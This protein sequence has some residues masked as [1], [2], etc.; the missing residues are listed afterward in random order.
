MKITIIEKPDI[1]SLTTHNQLNTLCEACRGYE[2][3][4]DTEGDDSFVHV[5]ALDEHG[6]LVGFLG[7][8]ILDNVVEITALV[9]PSFRKQGIFKAMLNKIKETYKAKKFIGTI[10][11]EF[12]QAIKDSSIKPEYVHSELLMKLDNNCILTDNISDSYECM[13]SDDYENFLMYSEDE[14]EPVAVCN[15]DFAGSFTNISGVF[16]DEDMR[17]QGIGTIFM[18]ELINAY[19]EEFEVPVILHVN[20]NNIAAIKLYEKCGFKTAECVDYYRF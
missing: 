6:N 16:V 10:P 1:S 20:S 2:P 5:V 17:D 12:R 8:I 11:D 19:F 15:L 13:F 7:G 18:K 3:Y 14:D 9:H 4:Y